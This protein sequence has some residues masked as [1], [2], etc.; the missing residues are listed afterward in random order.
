MFGTSQAFHD[1]VA[2]N[3]PQIAMLIFEDCVF[4][5]EDINVENGIQFNDYFNLEEDMAIGQTPSNEITF[6]LFNDKRLLNDYEFGDFLATIGVLIGEDTYQQTAP[7]LMNTTY[8]TWTGDVVYPYV[9]RNGSA[10]SAQPNFAVKS[11]IG[12]DG[13]VYAFSGDGRYAVYDDK[14]GGNITNKWNVSEH[15][16]EKTK[17]WDGRAYFYNTGTRI[18]L[19]YNAGKRERYEF[20]PLGVFTAE[21]PN[22]PDVI[23][24]NMTCYDFMQKFEKDMPSASELS[25]TY[26]ATIGQLY[27]AMC[28]YL[29]VKPDQT[30]FINAK[31]KISAEPDDFS[32]VT[33]RDVLKWIA[34]AAA[35]NARF[36]RDGVLV[37]DWI[38]E[39]DQSFDENNYESFDPY[40][41]ETKSVTKVYN[42]ASDG[43]YDNTKGTGDEGYLIQDNPLLKG[44]S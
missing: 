18:L 9:K 20:C 25:L 36:N 24:M 37:L 29:E 16:K 13:R 41:Y 8:A 19:A 5:N 6:T 32:N 11:M 1:A 2:S 40:W 35:A 44:V 17:A 43:S 28:D 30:E 23:Q 15:M 10:V 31:A 14:T 21:R 33:M 42:R 39:T 12:F 22:A 26:P 34:E 38:R 4:T 3:Q 7:V 27:K